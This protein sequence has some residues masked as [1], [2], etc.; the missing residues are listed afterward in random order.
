MGGGRSTQNLTAWRRSVAII[1]AVVAAGIPLFLILG[2]LKSSESVS[3]PR[4]QTPAAE[5]YKDA[6]AHVVST[7]GSLITIVLTILAANVVWFLRSSKPQ[8]IRH[9]AMYVVF[10]G[11]I[12]SLYFGV[13]LGYSAGLTLSGSEP[14]INPLLALLQNQALLALAS[15]LLLTA[16]VVF[17]SFTREG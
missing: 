9:V 14:E 3:V 6:I 13:K 15:G 8:P 7:S 11:C 16:V 1:V 4:V 5:T 17:S 10:T 12:I 2:V